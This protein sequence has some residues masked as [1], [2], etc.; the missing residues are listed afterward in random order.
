MNIYIYIY[1]CMYVCACVCIYIYIYV[2][3]FS[4]TLFTSLFTRAFSQVRAIANNDRYRKASE[5]A[6]RAGRSLKAAGVQK[7]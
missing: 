7:R 5:I 4:K 6:A 1:V 2:Q 3:T